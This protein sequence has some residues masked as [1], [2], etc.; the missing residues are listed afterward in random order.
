ME[1]VAGAGL[2]GG[3]AE[4]GEGQSRMVQH[5]LQEMREERVG[6]VTMETTLTYELLQQIIEGLAVEHGYYHQATPT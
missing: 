6:Y 4:G 5:A 1:P 3:M 2:W